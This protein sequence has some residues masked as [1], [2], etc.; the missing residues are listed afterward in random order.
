MPTADAPVES[1]FQAVQRELGVVT[2]KGAARFTLILNPDSASF[3]GEGIAGHD[4]EI[5]KTPTGFAVK[6]AIQF[7]L[8]LFMLCVVSCAGFP[9]SVTLGVTG[10]ASDGKAW[11]L[12]LT[13]PLQMQAK[14][15][16]AKPL[17]VADG[18]GVVAVAP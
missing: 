1:S 2:P 4:V 10:T 17:S 16:P 6:A 5:E 7:A 14:Q 18:K 8:A 12:G 3:N 13:V 11:A 9:A 15:E